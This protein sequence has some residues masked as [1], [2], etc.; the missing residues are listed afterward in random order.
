[1]ALASKVNIYP[2]AILLPA[3]FILQHFINEKANGHQGGLP[4]NYLLFIT[5]CL[6]A[7]GLAALISFRVSSPMRSTVY[8]QVSSG[9]RT[10]GT[11]PPGNR[12]SRPRV[13]SAMGPSHAFIFIHKLNP[14]GTR[15]SPRHS[16][17]GWIP[18]YGLAN[19]Q[20][21]W[22]HALLWGWT[23]A[24]FLW[25]S[26]QFIPHALSTAHLS[27]AGDDGGMVCF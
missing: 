27:L 13:E 18:L 1:M 10:S 6:V 4:A 25:Q 26:L 17:V 11:T 12:R 19:H 5:A 16:R 21:E 14:L 22:R 2:L 8:C 23:A 7:G 20:S 15:S 9:L 24:Y 3:A